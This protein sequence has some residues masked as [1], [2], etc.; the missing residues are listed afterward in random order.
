MIDTIKSLK[1]NILNLEDRL[2]KLE[3]KAQEINKELGF[4]VFTNDILNL[5]VLKKRPLTLASVDG[6]SNNQLFFQAKV[7]F[8]NTSNQEIKFSLIADNITISSDTGNYENGKFEVNL[9]GMFNRFTENKVKIVLSI[10]PKSNKLVTICGTSLTLWGDKNQS[11]DDE[12]D[13]VETS[14]KYFLSYTSNE[15]IYLKKFNKTQDAEEVEFEYLSKGKSISFCYDN[16][17]SVVYIFYVDLNNNLFLHNLNTKEEIYILSN[18]NKVSAYFLGGKILFCYIS[19]GDCFFGEISNKI[20]ISNKKL[21]TPNSKYKDCYLH[22]NNHNSKCY[23]IIT[24]QNNENYMLE[25]ISDSFCSSEN[26]CASISL[27]ITE[28]VI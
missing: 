4:K 20:V 24:N 27:N 12:F 21:I 10:I 14:D 19:N 1:D 28:G 7:V 5:Q 17:N 13:A 15:R 22:F 18:V 23:L 11:N 8:F 6:T 2:A 3:N 9:S 25:S 26:I 16:I